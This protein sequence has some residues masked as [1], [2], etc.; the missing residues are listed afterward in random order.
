M[1]FS[2]RRLRIQ[3]RSED[4]VGRMG[5]LGRLYT[6]ETRVLVLLVACTNW[7]RN[8]RFARHAG[9]ICHECELWIRLRRENHVPKAVKFL[10]NV[11]PLLRH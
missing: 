9:V 6:V 3:V 4:S 5:R 2:T 10:E 8:F 11:C 7:F 1:N